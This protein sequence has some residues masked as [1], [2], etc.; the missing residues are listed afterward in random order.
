MPDRIA[1]DGGGLGLGLLLTRRIASVRRGLADSVVVCGSLHHRIDD[2]FS[3]AL[4]AIQTNHL[5]RRDVAKK[6][7]PRF[8]PRHGFFDVTVKEIGRASCRERVS[9]PV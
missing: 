7:V 4:I 6:R 2:E 5:F 3:E 9:S 1:G 8:K